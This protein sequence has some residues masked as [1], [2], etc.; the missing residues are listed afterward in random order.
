MPKHLGQFRRDAAVG[1]K[2]AYARIPQTLCDDGDPLD[3]LVMTR[4]VLQ[5]GSVIVCR[6]VG[7]LFLED[8]AGGDEKILAVPVTKI[9][10]YYKDV[11]EYSHLPPI[12]VSPDGEAELVDV[13]QAVPLGVG[14]VPFGTREV[15]LADGTLLAMF[16]D[17]LVEESRQSI[18]VGMRRVMRALTAK[19]AGPL[20]QIADAVLDTL[21]GSPRDDVALVLAQVGNDPPTAAAANLPRAGGKAGRKGR[22]NG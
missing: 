14:G 2:G 8:E 17:G 21:N 1:N 18:D 11:T 10:P 6:P 7:V 12:V 4:W 15:E 20:E 19:D 13:S 9:S 3:C 16:T 22:K 5:P